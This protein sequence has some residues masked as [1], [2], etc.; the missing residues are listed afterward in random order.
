MQAL[1]CRVADLPARTGNAGR[2]SEP[3]GHARPLERKQLQELVQRLV[4]DDPKALEMVDLETTSWRTVSD[5]EDSGAATKPCPVLDPE[6]FR[7]QVQYIYREAIS[8]CEYGNDW[9][10]D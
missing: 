1:R 7:R 4:Q 8:A 2:T 10:A 6:P 3:C 9:E 5:D